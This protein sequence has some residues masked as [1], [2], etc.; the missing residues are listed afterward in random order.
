MGGHS[1]EP[2]CLRASRVP[3]YFHFKANFL[4]MELYR[5]Y[6]MTEKCTCASQISGWL[7]L[8][9]V[10]KP[11]I[12]A[13][14]VWCPCP[15]SWWIR[16]SI[17]IK[18]ARSEEHKCIHTSREKSVLAPLDQVLYLETISTHHS[19]PES[20]VY[21]QTLP[22]Y[23][24][25]LYF[26]PQS[27]NSRSGPLQRDLKVSVKPLHAIVNSIEDIV[28]SAIIT[29]PTDH[30]IRIFTKNN[31]LDALTMTISFM[32]SKDGKDLLLTGIQVSF[33]ITSTLT[34]LIRVL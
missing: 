26:S 10:K 15:G 2:P 5:Q 1:N 21:P 25:P 23:N 3:H 29:N 28:I 13:A 31:V 24:A 9:P 8:I 4:W 6:V 19:R 32:V 22:I 11:T 30:D 12:L 14:E 7:H 33:L 20:P 27:H 17:C 34:D 16:R 18:Y